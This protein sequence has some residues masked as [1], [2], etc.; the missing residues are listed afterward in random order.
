VFIQSTRGT[1]GSGG[2]FRPFTTEREDGLATLAWLRGQPWCEGEVATTGASYLG[3]T[4]WA[5]APYADPPLRS[6]SLHVTAAKITAAF[7]RHGVPG[8][9]NALTWTGLIG[10]QERGLTGAIPNPRQLARLKRAFRKVPLQAADVDVTGA[11]VTFW[12][13]FT[14]T[15]LP[16]T[17]SGPGP[18]TTTTTPT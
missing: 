7:Y 6:V 8:L 13:D 16:G 9:P 10:T 14:G 1:F 3:H 11:P 18:T 17:S 12:R 2:L 15:R 5:V 4:Q